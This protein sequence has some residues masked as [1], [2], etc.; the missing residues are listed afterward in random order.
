MSHLYPHFRLHQV[1]GANTD[2][3]KTI[4][5]TA[6]CLASATLPVTT[7]LADHEASVR[8]VMSSG[9]T[10]GG[11]QV[12]Y[13]KPVSTGP[14]TDSDDGHINTF[15][16][17]TSQQ[18][19]LRFSHAVSPHLA[20]RLSKPSVSPIS[21]PSRIPTDAELTRSMSQWITS[22]AHAPTPSVGYVETAGG[23]HS[24]SPTGTSQV[25][26][27]RPLRL[28]TILIGDSN[29]GGISTTRSAYE[30]LLI[31]GHQI[32]AILLFTEGKDDQWGN[33][34]YLTKWGQEAGVSVWGLAGL[35]DASK[36]SW[37]GPPDRAS[38][39]SEDVTNMKA[40][41]RGLVF[42]RNRHEGDQEQVGGVVDVVRSLRIAHQ[43]RL[44]ELSGLAGRTRESCWWPFTQHRLAETDADV[45]VIDSAHGDFF[46]TWNHSSTSPQSSRLG[47][48]L[49]GSASWWTQCLGHSHPVLAQT[50]AKAAGRYGHVLFPMA[51]NAPA[52]N[53]SETLLGRRDRSPTKAYH[54]SGRANDYP[55]P[56]KGWADR[57]FFSDNGATGMEVA[58]KMALAS[59]RR[60][61]APSPLTEA[62]EERVQK[63]RNAGTLAGRRPREWKILGLTGSYHG[64]TIGAMDACQPSIYS[65]NVDWYKGRGEWID[66]PSVG[67]VRGQ[68]TITLPAG[69][70][71][72]EHIEQRSYTYESL[73]AIYDVASRL[74]NDDPL[75]PVYTQI[76][77]KW[78]EHLTVEQGHRFGALVIEPIILGAGGMIFVD[79][80][81]QRLLIDVVRSSTDLFSL[82]DPPLRSAHSPVV[83][84]DQSHPNDWSGIPVIFD[85]VFTGLYRLGHVTPSGLLGTHPDICVLAKILTGGLVP[86]SVTLATKSVFDTFSKDTKKKVDAL[87]HGHSYTAHPIGCEVANETLKILQGMEQGGQWDAD[88]AAW[89]ASTAV[90]PNQGQAALADGHQA[91]DGAGAG[92]G[93]IWSFWSPSTLATLSHSPRVAS[94]NALG[95]VLSLNLQ[96]PQGQEGY[97]ST[98]AVD[99]LSKLRFQG[100]RPATATA[101]TPTQG[102]TTADGAQE[103]TGSEDGDDGTTHF[104]IH[105]RPL[106]NVVYFM[107][108]LNTPKWVREQVEVTLKRELCG[109]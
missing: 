59:S 57:V 100:T 64:D 93:A 104:N 60:R 12:H 6:L 40:F 4:F 70:E 53:L 24:P 45:M 85:E 86:M 30:S 88:K 7:T 15:S 102:A 55:A 82:S 103:W 46:S 2:V 96:D 29:L 44:Q 56:G 108:S 14:M 87:L 13:V 19:L 69:A 58:F 35:R 17:P 67:L 37:G 22:K 71:Q 99:L 20:A 50:A 3:G 89:G 109:E 51:A 54:A 27:F 66:P 49:D 65:K 32:D 63:G 95:C 52:L 36:N 84:P 11:E 16:S 39:A 18:T 83:S 31:A 75:V 80:L 42:G 94:I 33:A 68:A 81:F 21:D 79:P 23:P 1:F 38:S 91:G 92:H 76:I 106:G 107:C 74:R 105:A 43:L 41:Y 61:Y 5:T 48:T 97:A 47:L 34:D 62:S 25:D 98:A 77:R 8:D 26:L 9:R 28:P 101:P 78:L 10:D 73:Q 90:Q 72:F